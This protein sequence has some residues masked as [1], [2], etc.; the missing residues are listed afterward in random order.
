MEK[1]TISAFNFKSNFS[2]LHI[3]LLNSMEEGFGGSGEINTWSLVPNKDRDS[4]G[5][6]QKK[7]SLDKL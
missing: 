3:E 5:F 4:L 1:L 6:T 7:I 2:A